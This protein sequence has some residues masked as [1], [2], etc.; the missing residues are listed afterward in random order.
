[1]F[2]LKQEHIFEKLLEIKFM[3]NNEWF[4]K[5]M[6]NKEREKRE[7]LTETIK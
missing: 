4:K 6:R 1:M 7:K 5:D 2:E 3:S